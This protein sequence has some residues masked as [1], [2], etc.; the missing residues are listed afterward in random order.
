MSP[1]G[2]GI[3]K[4][5]AQVCN[6]CKVI[7]IGRINTTIVVLEGFSVLFRQDECD[8]LFRECYQYSLRFV[9]NSAYTVSETYCRIR[10]F[11]ITQ[12]KSGLIFMM[13]MSRD[14]L[15]DLKALHLFNRI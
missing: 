3:S 2:S 6:K 1:V 12:C 7:E 11:T 14:R 4:I 8:I 10:V 13:R 15:G 5:I 9:L